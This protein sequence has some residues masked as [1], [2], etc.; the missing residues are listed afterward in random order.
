MVEDSA[1]LETI[2]SLAVSPRAEMAIKLDFRFLDLS[3]RF[4]MR[5][6]TEL[7]KCY[8]FAASLIDS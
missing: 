2:E 8:A 3:S 4:R 6:I 5:A 7:G 1:G